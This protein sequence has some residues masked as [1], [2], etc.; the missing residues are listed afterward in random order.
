M[1]YVVSASANGNRFL[2]FTGIMR[3]H[4]DWADGV[5][6]DRAIDETFTVWNA[7]DYSVVATSQNIPGLKSSDL[8]MSAKGAYAVSYGK[9]SFVYE[10]P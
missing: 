9:A 8:R 2:A 6:T 4:F 7:A 10:L 5:P 1:R 3:M